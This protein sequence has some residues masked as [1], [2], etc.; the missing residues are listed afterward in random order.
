MHQGWPKFIQNTWYATSDNGIAAML[1][2]P[3]KVKVRVASGEWVSIRETTDYPFREK[4]KFTIQAESD[5][6]F[7]FHL[8]IPQWCN[9]H[10]ITVN[11]AVQNH[12]VS[13]NMVVL[14][15]AWKPGDVVELYLAMDFRFSRWNEKSLGLERG[16]LVYA[17]RIEE[18]WREIT[19]EGYDDTFWEVL[20]K[21]PWNY[22][23]LKKAVEEG[24]FNIEVNEE[25]KSN[26][27]NLENAPVRVFTKGIRVPEWKEEKGSAGAIP[28]RPRLVGDRHEEEIVLIPYG[29]TTLRISQFPVH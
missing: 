14:N 5:V 17:L 6:E 16:P 18:E 12:E 3:S 11:G 24:D 4:I 22:A 10:K 21:S 20:P 9:S 25:V 29:C 2:G 28:W 1:Y 19:K 13:E 15:R 27:W 23:I 8:R 7:P 26:P